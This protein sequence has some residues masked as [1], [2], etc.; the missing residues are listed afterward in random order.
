L[1]SYN[2]QPIKLPRPPWIFF[3]FLG[4]GL[5][6]DYLFGDG[7]TIASTPY[8]IAAI[9]ISLLS[10]GIAIWAIITFHELNTTHSLKEPTS[11]VVGSGPYRFTRN[12]MYLALV[13]LLIAAAVLFLSIYLLMA[14]VGLWLILDRMII[15]PE[16]RYLG[17]EFGEQYR[18]YQSKKE[19][20][21]VSQQ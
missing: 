7:L 13:L 2:H 8:R 9:L 21:S 4:T 18:E 5:L 14:S 19:Q 6:L 12:P 11:T 17:S 10:G 1:T 15:A 3:T 20:S 16:E